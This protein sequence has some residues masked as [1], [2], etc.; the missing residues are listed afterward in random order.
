MKLLTTAITLLM[1]AM[2]ASAAD[3]QQ[4]ILDV[5]NSE[6]RLVGAPPLAWNGDLAQDVKTWADHL[7][8]S[9][10]FEHANTADGENLWMGSA[11]AYTYAQMAQTWADEKARFKNGV[12]P[13]VSTDGNWANVGHYT[14]MIWST[15]TEI[16]CAKATGN[17]WDIL[18]CRYRKPGNTYG[19]KS[20]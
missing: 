8:A 11:S 6:R 19:Q 16:G 15:T 10:R 17:N 9:G 7:A 18:V 5:H 4:Q 20:Y 12:F 13:D 2:P 14:Q 3:M 1:I